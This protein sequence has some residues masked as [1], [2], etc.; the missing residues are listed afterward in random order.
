MKHLTIAHKLCALVIAMAVVVAWLTHVMVGRLHDDAYR[1]RQ[2][3]LRTQVESAMAIFQHFHDLELS[4]DLTRDEAQS[5]AFETVVSMRY[6]PNGYLFGTSYDGYTLLHPNPDLVG[7]YR[8]DVQDKTGRYYNR[9]LVEAARNGGGFTSYYRSIPGK[10]PEKIFEK[11]SYSQ[12]FEPWQMLLGTGAYVVDIEEMIAAE[13]RRMS[14]VGAGAIAFLMVLALLIGRSITRPLKQV[15]EALDA[16]AAD[17]TEIA[18]PYTRYSTQAG[19]LAKSTLA[20]QDKVRERIE[21]ERQQAEDRAALD[22]ER[23]SNAAFQQAEAERQAHVVATIRSALEAVANGDLTVRCDDLGEQDA[24]LRDH[25]N[26]A[27]GKLEA[28]MSEVTIKGTD[29]SSSKDEIR[30]ASTELSRR[31]ERQAANLEETSAALEQLS[32]AVRQTAEGARDAATRVVSV[33]QE[34]ENSDAIVNDAIKA[35]SLIEDSSA[36]I[37]NIIGVIEDIAFQTN[38][39]ALNAGV[40]AARAGESGKGFAVVAQEVRELAQRSSAAAKD[41]KDQIAGSSAQVDN[42]VRLVGNTGEALKRI[43]TQIIAARDIVTNIAESASEQDTT[44]RSLTSAMNDMD[45]TTQQNAAMAEE[46][47]A[48]TEALANDT[49]QLLN[50]IN[51]FRVSGAGADM[52]HDMRMAG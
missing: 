11:L 39:L 5:L 36:Q 4:G 47:T 32:E 35:M 37:G 30:R 45:A 23:Q 41:V 7:S 17:D 42:G 21:L 1:T 27:I 10:D 6:E 19:R 13:M 2:D 28:A 3:M 22:A 15:R 50:L 43:F 34:T 44:L 26:T 25:F 18:I 40:E 33:S 12:G 9:D 46:T 24:A 29:I 52:S 14:L 16:V 49:E 8:L 51:R 38:L 20:L 31:T 48:S